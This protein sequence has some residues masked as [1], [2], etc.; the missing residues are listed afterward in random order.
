[1]LSLGCL[2][3]RAG[4]GESG[5]AGEAGGS[6]DVDLSGEGLWRCA[7]KMKSA[8]LPVITCVTREL[9]GTRTVLR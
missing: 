5:S 4:A 6:G 9:E 8:G 2:G 1:M 7:L 3:A